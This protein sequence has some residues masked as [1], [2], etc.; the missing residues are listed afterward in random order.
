MKTFTQTD[1]ILIL[2]TIK[3]FRYLKK[4]SIIQIQMASSQRNSFN[5]QFGY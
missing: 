2:K 1:K 3:I 4:P 5:A